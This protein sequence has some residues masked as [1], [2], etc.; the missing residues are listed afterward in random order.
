MW[1]D[2]RGRY[3]LRSL[4]ASGGAEKAREAL[5]SQ[6]LTASPP[7]TLLLNPI[8]TASLMVFQ[9]HVRADTHTRANTQLARARKI[10]KVLANA[11]RTGLSLFLF[12]VGAVVVMVSCG[13]NPG[14][15]IKPQW[16]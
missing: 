5:G 1:R 9:T 11:R 6:L 7:C 3:D 10:K 14:E 12:S 15:E 13:V 8:K 16:G 4:S 2:V